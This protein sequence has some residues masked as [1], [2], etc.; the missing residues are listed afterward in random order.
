MSAGEREDEA[1]RGLPPSANLQCEEARQLRRE[2][3]AQFQRY[4]QSLKQLDRAIA[5]FDAALSGKLWSR[6]AAPTAEA[7]A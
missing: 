6:E 5:A 4:R 7:E 1:M 2:C 3:R